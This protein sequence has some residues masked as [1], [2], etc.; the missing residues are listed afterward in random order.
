[1]AQRHRA[2]GEG[3]TRPRKKQFISQNRL[4]SLLLEI[5]GFLLTLLSLRC[6]T[7]CQPISSLSLS[8]SC[9]HRLLIRGPTHSESFC[10]TLRVLFVKEMVKQS[11]LRVETLSGLPP[12]PT[13]LHC[14]MERAVVFERARG[15]YQVN[16][17]NPH[18]VIYS[19]IQLRSGSL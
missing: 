2:T 4:S 14:P 8:S 1:M 9:F 10:R 16:Q 12:S 7:E 13:G 6:R 18:S 19:S 17:T 3:S 5:L 11:L 15:F